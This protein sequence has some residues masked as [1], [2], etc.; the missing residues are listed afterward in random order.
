MSSIVKTHTAS[1]PRIVFFYFALAAMLLTL[2]GGLAFRQLLTSAL[3]SERERVQSQRRVIVPGPRGNIYDRESRLLVGNRPRFAV[4]LNLG[5]LGEELQA[6]AARVRE[7]FRAYDP[8]SVPAPSDRDRIAR[9]AVA[10]RH[11]D[12]INAILGRHERVDARR[13]ERQFDTERLLPFVL[14]DDLA[15]EEYARL[16]ERLPVDSP[17]QVYVTSNRHYPHGSAAAH[18][19]GYVTVNTDPPIEDFPGGD[20]ATFKMKGTEGRTGLELR[21]DDRLQGEAGGAIYQVDQ[22]GYRVDLPLQKR[23][24][25]QGQN[26]VTSLDLDLQ[27]AAEQAM[28]NRV[29]ACIALD[30]RTGEVLV[31]AS[32]PDY[33]LNEFSPR[34]S[35]AAWKQAQEAGGLFNRAVQ[36]R[37]PPGSTF[38]IVTALAALRSGAV[39]TRESQ[40]NCTG[41]TL[42]GRT[43]FVCHNHNG[44]GVRHLV[45]AIRDSCNIFFYHCGLETGAD[46]LAVEAR[47]FGFDHLTGIELPFERSNRDPIV[48]DPAWKKRAGKGAWNPGDTANMAIGQG[49]LEVSPLQVACFVASFARG[50]TETR[51]TLLHAPARPAQRTAPLGLSRADYDAVVEGMELSA[52]LGTARFVKVEGLRVAAK[53]GTAQKRPI[54]LAWTI[55][56]APIGN[57]QIAVAVVLE[58]SEQD[59]NF[60]GGVFAAPV[61]HAVLQAWFDKHGGARPALRLR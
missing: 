37:Y 15:P 20:L 24:P 52:Q 33:D 50:E 51:P 41:A 47:R 25:V 7:N 43:R 9:L 57:P 22:R 14:L 11:L 6:E 2:S 10:Q 3:Y 12:Q 55:A 38:K 29:G 44:H 32:K 5:G 40:T 34:I 42:I 31:L 8:R 17:L 18:T 28:T 4:T 60:A 56:F 13:L 16:I 19:L 46:F 59:N 30:V 36:G 26:L 39:D 35:T 23:L 27:L 61:A 53:T 48:P 54:E 1:K 58:G 49:E 21:F 45:D